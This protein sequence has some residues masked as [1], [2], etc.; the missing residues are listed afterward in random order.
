MIRFISEKTLSWRV[1]ARR[2]TRI[3]DRPVRTSERVKSCFALPAKLMSIQLG[4]GSLEGLT[5]QQHIIPAE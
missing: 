2:E 5:Q 4:D 3:Q 1:D